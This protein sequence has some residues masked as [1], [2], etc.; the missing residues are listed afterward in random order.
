MA[1]PKIKLEVIDHE[2][3]HFCVYFDRPGRI[4]VATTASG[5]VIAYVYTGT[6]VRQ[7]QVPLGMFDGATGL[8]EDWSK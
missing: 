2:A 5:K 7:E 1:K 8:T 3:Q 4:E 6:K